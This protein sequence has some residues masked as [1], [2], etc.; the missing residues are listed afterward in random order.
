MPICFSSTWLLEGIKRI[1]GFLWL[2]MKEHVV[3]RGTGTRSS[4]EATELDNGTSK[5]EVGCATLMSPK[6]GSATPLRDVLYLR[7]GQGEA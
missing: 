6:G 5:P 1:Q 7:G 2:C 3:S 4:R